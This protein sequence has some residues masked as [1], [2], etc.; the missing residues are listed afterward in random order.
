M[1]YQIK[2]EADTIVELGGKLLALAAQFQPTSGEGAK[3]PVMPEVKASPKPKPAAKA[4]DT[5]SSQDTSGAASAPAAPAE[6]ASDAGEQAITVTDD[7]LRDAVIALVKAKG[8]DVMPPLLA[9]FG[10]AKATEIT[11][12]AQ[13]LELLN[14]LRDALG[15]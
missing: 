4:E 7:A 12:P 1:S 2:I 14:A 13:R 5:S 9:Q 6:T 11:E 8:R 10:V 3:D 15:E